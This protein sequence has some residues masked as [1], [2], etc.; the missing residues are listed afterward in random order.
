MGSELSVGGKPSNHPLRCHLLQHNNIHSLGEQEKPSTMSF[1][2]SV[3]GPSTTCVC[4]A[5]TRASKSPIIAV[6]RPA[7]ASFIDY[8][9]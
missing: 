2:Y 7:Y 1:R 9:G 5:H 3:A 6:P 8:G 4:T